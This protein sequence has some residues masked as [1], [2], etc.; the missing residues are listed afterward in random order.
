MADTLLRQ[1]AMLRRMPRHPRAITV[2]E[3]V[4]GGAA[5]RHPRA[6]TGG[7]AGLPAGGALPAEARRTLGRYTDG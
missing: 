7:G 1:L 3:L 2:S 4:A 6:R 5:A